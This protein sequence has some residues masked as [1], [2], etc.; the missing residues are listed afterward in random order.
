MDAK[1]FVKGLIVALREPATMIVA[2][3]SACCP[4]RERWRTTTLPLR[5][6]RACSG[7]ASKITRT[8]TVWFLFRALSST[9]TFK[10]WAAATGFDATS[11]PNEDGKQ[12]VNNFN[13]FE[14]LSRLCERG[15]VQSGI[16]LLKSAWLQEK[17]TEAQ[18]TGVPFVLP[19]R[20]ALPCDAAHS[21]PSRRTRCTSLPFRTVGLGPGQPDPENRLLSD[22]CELLGYL[23]TTRHFGKDDLVRKELNIADREVLVFWDYPCLYQ[24]SDAH[25]PGRDSV[26]ARQ[27]RAGP[28]VD[29]RLVR[30]RRDAVPAMH[31]ELSS[32]EAHRVQRLRV[33]VLRVAG[34]DHDQGPGP[35]PSTCP[36]RSAGSAVLATT[37]STPSVTGAFSGCSNTCGG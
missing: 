31:R 4:P 33:A 12:H 24:K 18:R 36:P 19:S 27:L 13:D 16:C 10:A 5:P 34:L 25:D 22:V 8:P 23:D 7:A 29:Q 14:E 20:N 11:T 37:R 26:A 35:E 30:S 3:H 15:G 6:S 2:L 21:G 28:W 17:F 9:D 1:E 32:V